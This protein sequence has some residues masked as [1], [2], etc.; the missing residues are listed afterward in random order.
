MGT[1]PLHEEE[2]AETLVDKDQAVELVTWTPKNPHYFKVYRRNTRDSLHVEVDVGTTT[3]EDTMSALAKLMG[4]T[5][6]ST[7]S[8]TDHGR[9]HP[10]SRGEQYSDFLFWE[11]DCQKQ[12]D[13]ESLQGT[14]WIH[15]GV[16]ELDPQTVCR[17]T[18]SESTK[19]LGEPPSD[20]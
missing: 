8:A 1:V 13:D 17:Q 12:V 9:I 16:D 3:A 7:S 11:A 19:Q 20:P 6:E 5:E 14:G 4:T 15:E 18:A 2:G 10:R